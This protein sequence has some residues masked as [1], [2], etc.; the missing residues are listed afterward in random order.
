MAMDNSSSVNIVIIVALIAI[1]IWLIYPCF[2]NN[3]HGKE[4]FLKNIENRDQW[5]DT[6]ELVTDDQNLVR[7][8]KEITNQYP[9]PVPWDSSSNLNSNFEDISDYTLTNNKCSPACCSPQWPVPFKT[10][11]LPPNSDY[12]LNN[13]Y[14]NDGTHNSGC[15]CMKRN[16]ETYLQA[17]GLNTT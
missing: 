6:P 5:V 9:D 10:T 1:F 3:T 17:R 14:C 16:Q 12:V 4:G 11:K 13:Y 15:L 7:E 8:G 2:T